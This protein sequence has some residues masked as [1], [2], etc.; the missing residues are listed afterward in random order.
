MKD[1]ARFFDVKDIGF[2]I[3]TLHA[4]P[5]GITSVLPGALPDA[6]PDAIASVQF[7][8]FDS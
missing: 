7:F 8:C 6:L 3:Q 5:D 2:I 4:M 1:R